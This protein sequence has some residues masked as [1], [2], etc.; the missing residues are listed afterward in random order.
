VLDAVNIGPE[1][2]G[3]GQNNTGRNGKQ[4]KIDCFHKTRHGGCP[5]YE[6]RLFT[7][8]IFVT[9]DS[10]EPG[11]IEPGFIKPGKVYPKQFIR[12]S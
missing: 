12:T 4:N 6:S 2:Y 3:T 9:P 11:F 5:I 7:G 1:I 8:C 10:I